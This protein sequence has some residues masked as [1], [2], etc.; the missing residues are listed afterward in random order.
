M[1]TE[2]KKSLSWEIDNLFSDKNADVLQSEPFSSGGCQWILS[3]FPKGFGGGGHLTTCLGVYDP[4]KSLRS[5]WKRRIIYDMVFLNQSGKELHRK[6]KRCLMFCAE[7]SQWAYTMPL[8]NLQDKGF[9]DSNKV[10]I[11]VYMK[12]LEA[13]H[14][15]K[16][17]TDNDLV[18]FNGIQVLA[19]QVTSYAKLYY[20]HPHIFL[21]TALTKKE[22]PVYS[23]LFFFLIETLSK[24]PHS[25]SLAELTNVQ[26]G[27]TELTKAG[28]KMDVLK[29]KLEEVSGERKKALPLGQRIKNL[30][31]TLTDLKAQR[32]QETIKYLS[33][34]KFTSFEFI[35]LFIHRFCLS[36]FSI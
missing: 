36:C 6:D 26:N 34:A 30:E 5:G 4:C 25:L 33:T 35:N 7:A 32:D 8:T 24:S 2:L 28:F 9:F 27:L 11:E 29:S 3:V 13:F 1:E 16:S 12:V 15:G 22:N 19:S 20:Q 14:Q 18:D 17:S 31:L 10:T 21:D 23:A